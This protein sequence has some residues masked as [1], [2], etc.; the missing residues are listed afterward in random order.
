M[1]RSL[2]LL[3][4]L[5]LCVINTAFAQESFR[6]I[7]E[8]MYPDDV[9]YDPSIPTPEDFLG[10]PLGRAPVRYHELVDYINTVVGLS[11][12]MTVEVAGYSHE[13]R[14]ILFVVATSTANQSRID[15]IR[16]AHV[17]LSEPSIDQPVTD[18]MPVVTWLNY[19]VHGAE[20]SGMDAALPTV[21]YLAAARGAP[22]DRLLDESVILIAGAFNPDGHAYRAAW[23][24]AY[25]SE[26]VNADPNHIEH[27]FDGRMARTNHY[28]FDLNRQW[29]S[30]TQ[31]EPRAWMRKWHEWRPSV[32]VDY[33]EMG[34]SQTYY[35]APGVPTRTHPLI[36]EEG[37]NLI[38]GVV[39]PSEA[40]M[41]EQSRLYFH[42]DR[43]DHFF[44]GKGAA[45]PM[46]NG[47]LGIL[48]EASAARGVELETVNGIRTYREN[49]LK[50]FRTSI[51]NATGAANN[52]RALLEYQKDFYD[53]ASDRAREHAVKA[54][55]FDAPGD[56]SR[57]NH[58][59]DLLTF[60]R[61]SV[62]QL[63]RDVTQDGI[64]YRAGQAW[65]VPMDQAQHTLIRSM[66][67]RM[68]E[69]ADKTFYDVSS[70][71]VPLAFG[72]DYA[73]LSG[74][75]ISDAI[76]GPEVEATFDAAPT[77]DA[78]R[79]AYAFEW[80]EYYAPR[81]LWRVLDAGLYARVALNPLVAQTTRGDVEL[82]RGTV[83]VSFD[84]QN[85]SQNDI[86]EI[87][88]TITA[89]DGV[90]VHSL[91]SGRSAI[92]TQGPDVG[93][94][95]YRPLTRPE[96]LVIAGRDM[97]WYN[98]GEIWH[99]LDH[100]MG[101]QVT[102][103][104]RSRLGSVDLNRYTHIVF[105]GG[106]FGSYQP[107]YL[108]DL[109]RWVSDGGTLIGIRQGA[110][111]IR[112]NV[113]DASLSDSDESAGSGH[114]EFLETNG[115]EP[116]RYPYGEKETRDPLQLIG[117]S[118]FAGDLDNTHPIGFGYARRSIALHKNRTDIFERPENP[119]ASVVTYDTPSLL[120]GY[121]S[122]ENQNKLEG[123]AAVIAERK[124]S[125]SVILYADDPN[126][127]AIWYGTNKLFLN[128]LFFSKAFEA[129][130]D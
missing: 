10:R 114:D 74:R 6:S 81:A 1:T 82:D 54:Y 21:Y 29:M 71:T 39:A 23:L 61:I 13:R 98:A 72:V 123:T 17:A 67:E 26:V 69:F 85:V 78:P 127:R 106:S 31:P 86:Y 7:D 30:V 32:S 124:D 41:D 53:S 45:F 120:S 126:F 52:R 129:P 102:L 99:L 51:G 79:Y 109:R 107:G 96:I 60:H 84:R 90:T 43:Y 62:H 68:T 47:G 77:P 9:S 97:D 14:P 37:Y 76:L 59:V 108:V 33:H 16:Q 24:D 113:L 87:M 115:D 93:G 28:G 110:E 20:S 128:S 92:G 36:P 94:Q 83:I 117:G 2:T 65:I 116:D 34:S 66:F 46:V 38:S 3:C 125:G 118:I 119:Y 58:L 112:E 48:H 50:H 49:I 8:Q 104:D 95:F 111:W 70:W 64:T 63:G 101:M 11:D 18:D 88:Q 130:R 15:E 103:R 121:A 91:T 105:A 35:F 73:A 5:L 44:L 100:R 27:N 75:R 22:V 122:E 55:V 4:S 25:G 42:G 19:G 89:E 80:S 57:A 12:R 56:R 40:F